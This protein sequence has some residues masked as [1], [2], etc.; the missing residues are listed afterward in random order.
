[1]AVDVLIVE[2]HAFIRTLLRAMLTDATE[3]NSVTET[4]N[5]EDGLTQARDHQPG[6]ILLGLILNASDMHA[7]ITQLHQAAP[8]ASIIVLGLNDDPTY[9]RAAL[10]AGASN[11]LLKDTVPTNLATTIRDT[12]PPGS[13][14][15]P[16][17][18]VTLGATPRWSGAG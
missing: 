12:K 13:D 10:T 7:A 17:A 15:S 3:I 1:M 8:N 9:K 5:L 6:A 2:K 18:P 16:D 14:V 11:Y 4:D